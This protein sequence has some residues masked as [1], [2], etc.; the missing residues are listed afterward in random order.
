MPQKIGLRSREPRG[1]SESIDSV[2]V[3]RQEAKVTV[4]GREG[5]SLD[6]TGATTGQ[7]CGRNCSKSALVVY[8]MDVGIDAALGRDT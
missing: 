6:G 5:V 7:R 1:P 4:V 8:P 3:S 2:H